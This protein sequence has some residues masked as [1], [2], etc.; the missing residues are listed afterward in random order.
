MVK[1]GCL[2]VTI[3]HKMMLRAAIQK[4]PH[5]LELAKA[6]LS[7]DRLDFTNGC[8]ICPNVQD[9]SG[10]LALGEFGGFGSA[11]AETGKKIARCSEIW[12]FLTF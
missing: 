2:D 6:A 9:F 10:T 5:G 1:C 3:C 12:Q 7:M 8:P 4:H 11:L